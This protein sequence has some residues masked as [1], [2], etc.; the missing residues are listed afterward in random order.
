MDK[1]YAIFDMDGTLTDSMDY[2]RVLGRDY[3][4]ARG[5]EVTTQMLERMVALTMT[6]TARYFMDELGM[7]GPEQAII[8]GLHQVMEQNYRQKV[9]LRPGVADY[10]E[11]LRDRGVQMCVATGTAAPLARLCLERLEVADY[12]VDILSCEDIGLSKEHPDIYLL[13]AQ[14][15]GS[16]PGETAVF[17]DACY[18]AR[19]AKKAGFYTV[20]VYERGYDRWWGELSALADETITDWR[21]LI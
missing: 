9:P 8:D 12:F 3:L 1:A 11:R 14:R 20:G 18:A 19:T 7:P 6:D 17:E 10:L 13:A 16:A 4:A 2:W 15:L 5:V 21:E